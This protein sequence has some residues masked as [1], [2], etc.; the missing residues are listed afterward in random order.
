[1]P[2]D[3]FLG[4]TLIRTRLH[5]DGQLAYAALTASCSSAPPLPSAASALLN[6]SAS[7][8]DHLPSFASVCSALNY[9]PLRAAQKKDRERLP[10]L[11]LISAASPAIKS[12]WKHI[13]SNCIHEVLSFECVAALAR[14]IRDSPNPD[15]RPVLEVG[16]GNGVLSHH[17]R[18][19]LRVRGQ[20]LCSKRSN[21][22][23]TGR[24]GGAARRLPV[25]EQTRD[26]TVP[27]GG[28]C[29]NFR[30]LFSN[31]SFRGRRRVRTLR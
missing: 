18:R 6:A 15:G 19:E 1:M 10:N 16:A 8:A 11:A 17:L 14:L 21:V 2:Q 24:D 9:P 27:C 26:D 30:R 22:R 25:E 23:R 5:M 28:C 7:P 3:T 31:A 20:C 29:R 4:H 13:H 12:L